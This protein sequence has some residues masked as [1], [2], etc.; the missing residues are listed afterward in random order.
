MPLAEYLRENGLSNHLTEP[1]VEEGKEDRSR[2]GSFGGS[3]MFSRTLTLSH[4]YS[5][6]LR[7]FSHDRTQASLSA[8]STI[9][10]EE[11]RCFFL[12]VSFSKQ[13]N[14]FIEAP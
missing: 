2:L 14:T 9:S 4:F 1:E 7:I 6:I 8:H 5:A 3:V 10:Q 13:D 11:K 12:Y